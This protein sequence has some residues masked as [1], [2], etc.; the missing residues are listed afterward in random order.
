MGK[1]IID[2]ENNQYFYQFQVGCME[3]PYLRSHRT[4]REQIIKMFS[5][6]FGKNTLQ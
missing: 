5:T 2:T 3:N 6:E 1:N 4:M